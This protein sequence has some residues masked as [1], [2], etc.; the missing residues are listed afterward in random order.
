VTIDEPIPPTPADAVAGVAERSAIAG[1]L[2]KE[3]PLD[4]R[5]GMLE[6]IA[7]RLDSD[8][9]PLVEVAGA[10]THLPAQRL[11]G[12]LART[13]AQLRL[14]A[15]V[16]REGSFLEA[17][18]DHADATATPPHPEIRRILQPIGPVG[19]FGASN[20]PFAFSVAGGDT[21]SALAAGCPVIVKL[22]E[23]HPVL[24]TMTAA[25]VT[26]AMASVDAPPDAFAMIRGRSAGI[27]LVTAPATRAVGF[28][29][30]ERG[31]RALFD[32]AQS[33]PDPIPFYGELGSV[34]AAAIT[35][36][37]AQTR[38]E[39]IAVG[40][41][42]SYTL[43]AGQFCTKPGVALVPARSGMRSSIEAAV[44]D[45]AGQPMLT[46]AIAAG[47]RAAVDEVSSVPGVRM[48]VDAAVDPET[49][50]ATPA[51]LSISAEELLAVASDALREMFGPACL[52]VE[53]ETDDELLAALHALAPALAI[54]VHAE[55][56]EPLAQRLLADAAR[57]AGRVVWNGWT[58]GVA[59]TWSMH[60]GGAWPSTTAS[61]H[62][63]VGATATRRFMTPV[64]FQDVPH[65]LLPP[66]L[67]D[68]HLSRI[69]RRVDGE[70]RL[71]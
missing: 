55:P 2:L 13:T 48:L 43:G 29:G 56:D 23:G 67:K 5:A 21:A 68:K 26:E 44:A 47:F 51:L 20:F 19:V 18:V 11:R 3:L 10:E 45:R 64:A 58:T 9:D 12:E 8:A 33:R 14:F 27:A 66:L 57:R 63:S 54:G 4:W 37:A 42:D 71:P 6:S 25:L 16:V 59:V 49:L 41:V 7:Q 34:N 40:L 17:T 30:S 31:G 24:S 52:I 62:T 61:I 50:V 15:S 36:A 70:L 35:P 46:S 28:T 22:H 53:Y 39:A 1:E 32:L 38:G 60:H 69:V 65:D